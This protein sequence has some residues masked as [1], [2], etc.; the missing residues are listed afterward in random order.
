M[1][2]FKAKNDKYEANKN[3]FQLNFRAKKAVESKHKKCKQKIET[4]TE[5]HRSTVK[6]KDINLIYRLSAYKRKL[7]K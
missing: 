6:K 2:L 7:N 1:K 5:M 3:V 4:K